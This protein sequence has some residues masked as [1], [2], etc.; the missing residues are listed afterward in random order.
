MT[1][2]FKPKVRVFQGRELTHYQIA[3]EHL[4]EEERRDPS[5]RALLKIEGKLREDE[6]T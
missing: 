1:I 6:K 5:V 2:G 3:D 4:T